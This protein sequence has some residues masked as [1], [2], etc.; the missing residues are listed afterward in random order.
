[1][2]TGLPRSPRRW[3]AETSRHSAAQPG[4]VLGEQGDPRVP[5]VDRRAAPGRLGATGLAATG[6]G[7]AGDPRS[8][9]W[10]IC[11]PASSPLGSTARSTPSTGRMPAD[12][13]ARAN[14]TAP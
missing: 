6:L 13:A 11:G 7:P 10:T 5:G 12:C 14:F 9:G 2:V 8:D 1:M 3:V 4:L